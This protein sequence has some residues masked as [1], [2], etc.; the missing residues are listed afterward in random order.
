MINPFS[1]WTV[2]CQSHIGVSCLVLTPPHQLLGPFELS[3]LRG[4]IKEIWDPASSA[5]SPAHKRI[6][7][8]VFYFPPTLLLCL[9]AHL[10]PETHAA[11]QAAGRPPQSPSGARPVPNPRQKPA[12]SRRP[13]RPLSSPW[14]RR[15]PTGAAAGAVA[16]APDGG[17]D[18]GS[19]WGSGGSAGCGPRC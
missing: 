15:Q 3:G 18:S 19:A 16:S 13:P 1:M 8:R 4:G 6:W 2:S 9:A 10:Q 5:G 14:E 11:H 7:I 17:E 12:H